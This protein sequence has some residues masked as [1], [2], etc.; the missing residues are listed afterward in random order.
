MTAELDSTLIQLEGKDN[1]QQQLLQMIQ[2]S[3]RSLMMVLPYMLDV[4]DHADVLQ[5]M[6]GFLRQS[7]QRQ[8]HILINSLEPQPHSTSHLLQLCQR[9]PSRIALRQVQQQLSSPIRAHDLIV[10]SD[11][12]HLLRVADLGTYHS[13]LSL[14][15]PARSKAY[16]NAIQ[17]AWSSAQPIAAFRQ[18]LI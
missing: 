11:A 16:I 2:T 5:A 3:R 12:R 18:L 13:W 15:S 17:A 8:L 14:N 4:F 10:I 6:T 9:L 1:L 7:K